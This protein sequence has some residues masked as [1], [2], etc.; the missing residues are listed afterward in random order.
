M[1]RGAGPASSTHRRMTV[2]VFTQFTPSFM[3]GAFLAFHKDQ[4]ALVASKLARPSPCTS[5]LGRDTTMD[6][7]TRPHV[8]LSR[9]PPQ[10]HN[11]GDPNRAIP[12]ELSAGFS[13][14]VTW[15]SAVSRRSRR[16][17]RGVA[18]FARSVVRRKK[19]RKDAFVCT[20]FWNHPKSQ[21]GTWPCATTCGQH[22]RDT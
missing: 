20:C 15:A 8:V 5:F 2:A 10:R 4:D 11:G 18:T 7:I 21:T 1:S 9:P 19:D 16:R 13:E 6:P 12:F 22:A 3:W 17:R 14:K